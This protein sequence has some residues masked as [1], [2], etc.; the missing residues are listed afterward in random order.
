MW[1]HKCV[2]WMKRS[3]THTH[4]N[5][6][7]DKQIPP[8]RQTP[9]RMMWLYPNTIRKCMRDMFSEYDYMYV[10]ICIRTARTFWSKTLYGKHLPPPP[11]SPP[12]QCHYTHTRKKI[13]THWQTPFVLVA[14]ERNDS[15]QLRLSTRVIATATTTTT[16]GDRST[17][18]WRVCKKSDG[19]MRH[20]LNEF[21]FWRKLRNWG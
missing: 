19:R 11:P 12:I 20:L 16:C 15:T 17:T 6:I 7:I 8:H 2:L 9:K 21:R 3:H 14:R 13:Y 4:R 1:T 10:H 5:G 18:M